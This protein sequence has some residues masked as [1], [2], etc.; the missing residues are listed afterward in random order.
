MEDELKKA[1]PKV[2]PAKAEP[3][4]VTKAEPKA[5]ARVVTTTLGTMLKQLAGLLNTGQLNQ[6]EQG[7]VH[8][9][10][11]KTKGGEMKSG[12]SEYQAAKLEQI[13]RQRFA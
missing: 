4:K 1:P 13:Y 12:L 10:Y 9:M 5:G 6:W 3:A 7:F 11:G 8:E 2:E